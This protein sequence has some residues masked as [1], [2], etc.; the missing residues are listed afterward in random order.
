MVTAALDDAT[1]SASG[2]SANGTA[3]SGAAWFGPY[4]DRATR[5]GAAGGRL[6]VAGTALMGFS[7]LS[8]TLTGFVGTGVHACSPQISLRQRITNYA[9]GIPPVAAGSG[10]AQMVMFI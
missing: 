7:L 6:I 4:L 10:Y 3:L 1:F 5:N 2:V 9:P 8:V